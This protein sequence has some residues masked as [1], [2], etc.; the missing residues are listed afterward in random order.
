MECAEQTKVD[1]KESHFYHNAARDGSTLNADCNCQVD[2]QDSEIY[3]DED[4][5]NNGDFFK[6][7]K[8]CSEI[9]TLGNAFF[10]GPDANTD[11][12]WYE[13]L[14]IIGGAVLAFLLLSFCFCL[15]RRRRAAK[16]GT[17]RMKSD[18]ESPADDKVHRTTH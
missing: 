17:K 11:T 10:G 1:M 7:N 16:K 4:R 5:P 3:R 8:D 12:E 14:A 15:W 6:I 13:W 18:I 9:S 2:I